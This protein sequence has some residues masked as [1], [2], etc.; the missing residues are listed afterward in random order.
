MGLDI[1]RREG[2]YCPVVRCDFCGELIEDARQ[3]NYEWRFP[4]GPIF[5]THKACCYAFE[6]ANGGRAAWGWAP[7]SELPPLLGHNLSMDGHKAKGEPGNA[8]LADGDDDGK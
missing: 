8:S 4:A 6:D 3:G 1:V 5:Y 7:L 2:R